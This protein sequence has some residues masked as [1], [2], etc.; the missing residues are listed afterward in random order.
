MVASPSDFCYELAFSSW[1]A[2]EPPQKQILQ[3]AV[4]GL[5]QQPWTGGQIFLRCSPMVPWVL[6]DLVQALTE[7]SGDVALLGKSCSSQLLNLPCCFICCSTKR[8]VHFF[9]TGCSYY[10][11]PSLRQEISCRL[12]KSSSI[13]PQQQS[14]HQSININ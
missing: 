4:L 7:L 10:L 1:I 8:E 12:V 5:C 14:L 13:N 2:G 6:L 9:Q 3:P 11:N